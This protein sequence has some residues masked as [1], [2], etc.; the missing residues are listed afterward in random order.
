[1]AQDTLFVEEFDGGIPDS[2]TTSGVNGEIWSWSPDATADEIMYN[3][4]TYS[5]SFSTG[6]NLNSLSADNGVALFSSD[7]FDNRWNG[8]GRNGAYTSSPHLLSN[9]ACA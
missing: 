3:D 4:T 2:W 7:A 1:M 9:F 8:Y 6:F 5:A